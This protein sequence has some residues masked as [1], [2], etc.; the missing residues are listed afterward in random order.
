MMLS[1]LQPYNASEIVRQIED[2]FEL[3]SSATPQELDTH[4]R[5][6]NKN[7]SRKLGSMS[8]RPVKTKYEHAESSKSLPFLPFTE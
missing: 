6:K 7:N 4:Q 8:I 3:E 1:K 5:L 2:S